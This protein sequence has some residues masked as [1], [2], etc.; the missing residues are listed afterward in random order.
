MSHSLSL[1]LFSYYFFLYLSLFLFLFL[2][3]SLSPSLSSMLSP[4]CSDGSLIMERTSPRWPPPPSPASGPQRRRCP[5]HF[6][7][8]TSGSSVCANPTYYHAVYDVRVEQCRDAPPF[9]FGRRES[10]VGVGGG[11]GGSGGL[12]S[13]VGDGDAP[14][15]VPPIRR[16][17]ALVEHRD[18]IKAHQSHKLQSTPQARRKEWE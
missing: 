17:G 12:Y 10:V 4:L 15:P 8:P 2:P 5:P 16:R 14:L 1:S 6:P 3:L 7:P 18:I 9:S 13:L 11:A